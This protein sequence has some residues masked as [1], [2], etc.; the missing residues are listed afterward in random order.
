MLVITNGRIITD[1]EIIEGKN[2]YI[3]DNKIYEVTNREI[4]SDDTVIDA[5][6]NYVS[7]GF[8]DMHTHGCMGYNYSKANEDEIYKATKYHMEH[9]ATSMLVTISSITID[10]VLNALDTINKCYKNMPNNI[11]GVHLEGPY[12][13]KEMCGAQNTDYITEPIKEDYKK[14]VKD[15][16][17]IVKLWSYAP[18]MDVNGEFCKYISSNGIIPSAGHTNAQYSHMLTAMENGC[19]GVTH[20]Y[21][22]T[23]TI[24]REDG[25]RRLGVIETAF[26]HDEL[27]AEIIADGKHLPPELIRMIYKVKG[28]DN[29]CLVTDSVSTAGT[30]NKTGE[31]EGIKYIID[32]G[33]CKKYDRSCF[34]GSI[35][36]P[37]V[38]VRVCVKEAKLPLVDSVKMMSKNP[39]QI[40]G[41]N[42]GILKEGYDAD[43]LIF[44]N[45]INIK[46]VF[47][48]GKQ[49]I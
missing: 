12:F 1:K 30:K 35:A 26:L 40:L 5:K 4:N 21:S 24:T 31:L 33:V 10:N 15:Y 43:V 19:K 29:I 18:E 27:Y 11:V 44:D 28:S 14:I 42:K 38:L 6:G 25:F 47:I 2:L 37:D 41:L 13:S 7:P 49:I 34:V 23:S 17:D 9:G 16:G 8:I 20:L 32:D 46:N 45:D 36:S 22:C 3:K 39:A 48:N